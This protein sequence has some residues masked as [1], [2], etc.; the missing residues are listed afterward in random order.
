MPILDLIQED[1]FKMYANTL[2]IMFCQ[3]QDDEKERET[4]YKC[5]YYE[6]LIAY[7]D[8][9]DNKNTNINNIID[10]N[11]EDLKNIREL[12]SKIEFIKILISKLQETIY[13][14]NVLQSIYDLKQNGSY[15]SISKA[16]Y[17]VKE[18][19]DKTEP[20][21]RSKWNKCKKV[22]HIWLAL[23]W[24]VP[25]T[26]ESDPAE[27]CLNMLYSMASKDKFVKVLSV[28]EYIRNELLDYIPDFKEDKVWKPSSE[29]NLLEIELLNSDDF[30]EQ[31]GIY[32][33]IL[34]NYKA[35][36]R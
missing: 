27:W 8:N 32:D 29:F 13:A 7:H 19:F 25:D 12:P 15:P 18:A 14:I 34:S 33:R 24:M 16:V 5:L 6:C 35:R 9:N 30:Q 3:D 28:S 11:V 22:S 2:S 1:F 4:I 26:L 23:H 20:T 36:P 31:A 10:F 21:V 17:I